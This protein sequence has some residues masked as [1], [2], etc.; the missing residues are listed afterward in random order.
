MKWI[1]DFYCFACGQNNPDGLK[2]EFF[3][4]DGK[5]YSEYTFPK[6]FQGYAD[7]VHGGLIGLVLDEVMVNLPWR[8]YKSYV[9]SAEINVRFKKPVKI[10]ER[11]TF[12]AE[13]EKEYKNLVYLKS[14][15]KN[16]SGEVVATA[17]SKC[18]RV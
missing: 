17:T 16:E 12:M 9:V 1:D 14:E 10:G 18:L 11:L 7:V 3:I 8:L 13:I 2:L 15:A 6:K 5:I 4:K